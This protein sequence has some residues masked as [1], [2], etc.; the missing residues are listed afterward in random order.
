MDVWQELEAVERE[1]LVLRLDADEAC[2]L[3]QLVTLWLNEFSPEDDVAERVWQKLYV[4][5]ID[6]GAVPNGP[7]FRV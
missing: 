5:V 3:C 6:K 2:R 1:E 4:G 7:G